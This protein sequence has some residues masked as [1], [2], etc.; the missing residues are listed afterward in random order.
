MPSWY[1]HFWQFVTGTAGPPHPLPGKRRITVRPQVEDLEDRRVPSSTGAPII[2]LLPPVNVGDQITVLTL[3]ASGK[4][5]K[6]FRDFVN[7]QPKDQPVTAK[8]DGVRGKPEVTLR[9]DPNDSSKVEIQLPQPIEFKKV[10][11]HELKLKNLTTPDSLTPLVPIPK[12]KLSLEVKPSLLTPLG[13]KKHPRKGRHGPPPPRPHHHH[14]HHHGFNGI[15][16]GGFGGG[17]IG[18][19]G[20][21]GGGGF[22][23]FG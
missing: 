7:I 1:H 23:G 18:I 11:V 20:F 16:I 22:N 21:G 19:G 4:E 15:G 13:H 10:G 6:G 3:D 2:F 5:F 9:P 17:G 12:L 14:H 8:L